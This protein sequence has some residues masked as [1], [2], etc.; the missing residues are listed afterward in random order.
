MD[1]RSARAESR[2]PPT[3]GRRA[4]RGEVEAAHRLLLP[5]PNANACERH[6]GAARARAEPSPRRLGLLRLERAPHR[7]SSVRPPR[8]RPPRARLE[9]GRRPQRLRRLAPL[10]KARALTPSGVGSSP[11][12]PPASSDARPRRF[13][14]PPSR[15]ERIASAVRIRCTPP[16]ARPTRRRRRATSSRAIV[17]MHITNAP[18]LRARRLLLEW[19][20][21]SRSGSASRSAKSRAVSDRRARGR[22]SAQPPPPRLGGAP[23]SPAASSAPPPAKQREHAGRALVDARRARGGRALA[24]RPH[25][26]VEGLVHAEAR[27]RRRMADCRPERSVASPRAPPRPRRARAPSA[28]RATPPARARN[29]CMRSCSSRS[30]CR[31]IASCSCRLRSVALRAASRWWATAWEARRDRREPRRARPR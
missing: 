27:M 3:R 13:T 22:A 12:T 9:R 7:L 19:S 2:P 26:L 4:R 25:E 31:R 10:P 15:R 11:L 20:I 6:G 21:R 14:R 29:V 8:A 16:R 18:P 24:R 23:P 1:A 5:L 30:K 17:A 28:R